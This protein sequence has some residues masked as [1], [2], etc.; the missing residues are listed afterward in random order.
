MNA[1]ALDEK[2]SLQ[3]TIKTQRRERTGDEK[4]TRAASG[5]HRPAL[6]AIAAPPD[7]VSRLSFYGSLSS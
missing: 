7:T 4:G 3:A 6:E 1:A 5:S 2:N